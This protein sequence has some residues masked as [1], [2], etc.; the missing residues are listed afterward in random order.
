MACTVQDAEQAERQRTQQ[1]GVELEGEVGDLSE[2]FRLQDQRVSREQ[3]EGLGHRFE[4]QGDIRHDAE[5]GEYGDDGPERGR[6]AVAAGNEVGDTDN[7]L[8]AGNPYDLAQQKAP[9]KDDEGRPEVDREKVESR[10]GGPPHAAVKSPGCHV[11][12]EGER[13]DR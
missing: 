5:H 9:G 2:L 1:R 8:F 10:G 13:V 7:I 4:L 11:D 6:L 3:V 12:R